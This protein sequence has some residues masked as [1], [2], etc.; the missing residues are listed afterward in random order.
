M[1]LAESQNGERDWDADEV[2]NRQGPEKD[3]GLARRLHL[4]A[5]LK[6]SGLRI[7]AISGASA[8]GHPA[9]T[10]WDGRAGRDPPDPPT[11]D[12]RER[13]RDRAREI[14]SHHLRFL[15]KE[16]SF[17]LWRLTAVSAAEVQH[18]ILLQPTLAAI[19]T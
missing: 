11:I 5:C 8:G 14:A 1:L 15:S 6:K 18:A 16:K 4:G 7:V 3:R 17:R 9:E 13:L 10:H 2:P 12:H 19:G